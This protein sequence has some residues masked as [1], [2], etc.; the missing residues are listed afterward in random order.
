MY[1]VTP[2]LVGQCLHALLPLALHL[3]SGP[4][5]AHH[6]ARPRTA[7]QPVG[8]LR[9]AWAR[10]NPIASHSAHSRSP[11]LRPDAGPNPSPP[12]GP[13]PS[14]GPLAHPLRA[15]DRGSEWALASP[16]PAPRVQACRA[17]PTEG[18]RVFHP[19][20]KGGGEKGGG[21]GRGYDP[22]PGGGATTH[23]GK[24]GS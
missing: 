13:D 15:P 6:W 24:T 20:L 19:R 10:R 17:P 1:L 8:T 11:T 5:A 12:G 22:R 3:T 18:P 14:S 7:P 23:N 16:S 2:S 9:S 21:E 4:T